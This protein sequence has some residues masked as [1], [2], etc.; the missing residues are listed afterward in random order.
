LDIELMTAVAPGASQILVYEGTNDDQGILATYSRIASDNL[1]K[2]ISTSWGSPEES[3]SSSL[4]QAENNVFKQMAAQGQSIYAAAGDNGAYDDGSSLSVDDPGSNPN[5]VAVGGTRLYTTSTGA[6]DHETTWNEDGNQADGAGGGGISKI[7]S[8]PAWQQGLAT[9]QNLGSSTM[10]NTPD[11]SLNADPSTG[12]AIYVNGGWTTYGGT[13]CAAPLWAAFNALV[14]QERVSQGRGL[15]GLAS[16]ALYQAG[17]SASYSS[18][19][20]DIKDGST[21]IKYPATPGYDNATGWG[22]L[23]G[24]GL[25]QSL[26]Q[27]PTSSSTP[28][29]TAAPSCSP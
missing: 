17:R 7:W 9:A 15:V 16:P 8:I 20:Y 10:R 19:Y 2:N 26:V 12:Y 6:Y 13:S 18:N 23:N 24:T 27:D 1:A 29:G 11:V 4:I 21:N 14:N 28:T 3:V 25:L 5:V 22:S